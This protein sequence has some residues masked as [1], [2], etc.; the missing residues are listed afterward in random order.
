MEDWERMERRLLRFDPVLL[1]APQRIGAETH[2]VAVCKRGDWLLHAAAAQHNHVHA[3]LSANRD[4]EQIRHW[5]K[6]WLGRALSECWPLDYSQTWWASGGSVKWVWDSGYLQNVYEYIL[7][8]R[9]TK[10]I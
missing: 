3:L 10:R 8:Q 6:R 4:G 1:T 5:L 9:T 2:I 7:A